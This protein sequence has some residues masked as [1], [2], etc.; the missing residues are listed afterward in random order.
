MSQNSSGDERITQ[1]NKMNTRK[2]IY[3]YLF[4]FFVAS[5]YLNILNTH[6]PDFEEALQ[7]RTVS[8]DPILLSSVQY[9]VFNIIPLIIDSLVLAVAV[10]LLGYYFKEI[11]TSLA[12]LFGFVVHY[13]LAILVVPTLFFGGNLSGF[14]DV[15]RETGTLFFVFAAFKLIL[16]ILFSYLGLSF[17]RRSDFLTAED[18]D[19]FYFYGIRK[20]VWVLIL[21]LY[22]PVAEF[23]SRLTIVQIFRA[24]ERIHLWDFGQSGGALLTIVIAG[25]MSFALFY[26]G[27][28]TIRERDS[29]FRWLKLGS[30][31]GLVPAIVLAMPLIRNETWFF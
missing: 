8:G 9:W 19:L 25:G 4:S 27:I 22:N 1:P 11:K 16:T 30:V 23:L 26:Y 24:T 17:G 12:L 3:V 10:G 20:R 29:G 7:Y 5:N 13:H 21:F 18:E 6:L 2:H 15:V 31:F 28:E 14:G